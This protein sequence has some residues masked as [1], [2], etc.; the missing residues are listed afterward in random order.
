[1]TDFRGIAFRR[2]R[3]LDWRA[4]AKAL[5]A[6]LSVQALYWLVLD[7]WVFSP[8]PAKSTIGVSPRAR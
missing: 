7:P 5:L 4:V 6:I 2:N 8:K 3:L 1:M